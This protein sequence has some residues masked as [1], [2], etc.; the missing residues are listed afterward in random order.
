MQTG[1]ISPPVK[2]NSEWF[3]LQVTDRKPG[4]TSEFAAKRQEILQQL[5]Q[6]S[7]SHFLAL[8]YDQ[9]RKDAKVVDRRERTLN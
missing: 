3:I 7:S 2:G 5:R 6:E 4:E 1:K 9:L 8:W